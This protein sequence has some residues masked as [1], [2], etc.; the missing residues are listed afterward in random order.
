MA[1]KDY[2][3]RKFPGKK[4]WGIYDRHTG[5]RVGVSTKSK[6]HARVAAHIRDDWSEKYPKPK[7]Q[8]RKAKKKAAKKRSKKR[9]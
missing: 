4:K 9:K 5:K 2:K 7:Y 6:G 3:V 8:A 1:A